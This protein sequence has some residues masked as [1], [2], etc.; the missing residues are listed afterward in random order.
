MQD[1][2][3]IFNNATTNDGGGVYVSAG[4]SYLSGY[5]AKFTMK[6]NASVYGNTA[7]NGGGVFLP[8]SNSSSPPS[9]IMEGNASVSGNT[10]TA[11]GGG[12]GVYV[13]N[14]GTFEMK[15]GT[16]SGNKATNAASNG[17]GVYVGSNS[18][19]TMSG[20][21]I[22]GLNDPTLSNA[23]GSGVALYVANNG[24]AIYSGGTTITAPGSGV[25]T[26][27]STGAA[28]TVT[29]TYNINGGSGTT[30]ASQTVS[31]GSSITLPSG[32]GFSRTGY[33]FG[34]WNI[35]ASGRAA[36]YNAGSSYPVIGSITLYAKWDVILTANIWKDGTIPS[37]GE[38]EQWFRFTATDST[39][40][41][42][43]DFGTLTDLYVQL[44]NSD[45]TTVGSQTRLRSSSGNPYTS[46]TTLTSGQVYYV[47]VTPYS[48]SVSGTYQIAFNT[49]ATAP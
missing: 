46:Q 28:G 4:E 14:Y 40:Y 23:A 27:V 5:G 44:Y 13:G 37:S 47:R 9:F 21:R 19:F 34:G 41:L 15:G 43:I 10:S 22:Y 49:S 38:R 30:P 1:Y 3:K 29:V 45:Y 42:H 26:T 17:G 7:G 48:S 20:G 12:G 32:S 35:D 18:T 16:I 39:Q 25:D 6:G 33:T 24:A 8:N 36:N 31:A 11:S 2:A